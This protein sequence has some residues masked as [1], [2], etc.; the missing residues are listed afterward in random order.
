[1]SATLQLNVL[2]ASN[3]P[4]LLAVVEPALE[5]AGA[6]VREVLSAEAAREAMLVAQPPDLVLLDTELPGCSGM[7]AIMFTERLRLDVI[8]QPFHVPGHTVRLSACFGIAASEGRSP[9]VML[10]ES[11]I[12]LQKAKEAGAESI[13]CF[14]ES[15]KSDSTP[16]AFLPAAPEDDLPA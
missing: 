16:V 7:D 10:R 1:M 4:V 9:V 2:L 14:G 11:E 13:Q 15:N 3:D 6:R 12:A 5:G 8:A